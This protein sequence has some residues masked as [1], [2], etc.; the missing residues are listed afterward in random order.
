MRRTQLE[1]E[2]P[3]LF[4]P[5]LCWQNSCGKEKSTEILELFVTATILVTSPDLNGKWLLDL[6]SEGEKKDAEFRIRN[7]DCP[8]TGY[9]NLE[10]P[11]G[12]PS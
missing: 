2:G 7:A 6:E 9:V 3:S 10:S 5:V 8:L 11:Q 1:S 12:K 4:T